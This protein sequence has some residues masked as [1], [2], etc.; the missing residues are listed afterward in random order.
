MSYFYFFNNLVSCSAH[1]VNT[2]H[3][4]Y[5]H[6]TFTDTHTHTHSHTYIYIERE[7]VIFLRP[8]IF[9][10]LFGCDILTTSFLYGRMEKLNQ[11]LPNFKFTYESSQ[12]RV[13]FI[14]FNV[15]LEN[16]WITTDLYTKSTDCH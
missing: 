16:D 8:K 10:H 4:R 12:K 5:I 2:E 3:S 11:F 15:S 6:I 1:L 9:D 13:A 14:G 7:R